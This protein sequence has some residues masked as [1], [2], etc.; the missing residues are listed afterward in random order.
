MYRQSAGDTKGKDV[1][2]TRRGW[3]ARRRRTTRTTTTTSTSMS[4]TTAEA[5]RTSSR[6]IPSRRIHRRTIVRPRRSFR[7]AYPPTMRRSSRR[8][9][10]TTMRTTMTTTTTTGR[11][12]TPGKFESS[13]TSV[14]RRNIDE[15]RTTAGRS[16]SRCSVIVRRPRSWRRRT[17]FLFASS[18][19]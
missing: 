4:T 10:G 5:T 7:C 13:S 2:L 19:R 17:C 18:I 11:T 1:L 12:R 16:C 3:A 6:D 8:R 15:G 14:R 9:V